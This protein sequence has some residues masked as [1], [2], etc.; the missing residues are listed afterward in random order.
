MRE[1]ET[2][3]NLVRRHLDDHGLLTNKEDQVWTVRYSKLGG[4]GLY[5]KRDIKQGELIF[6]EAPLI[7]GPRCYNKYL[8]MCINCYKSGCPLFPCDRGCGLP[9]CSNQCENS[10]NHVE[11][12]C[13]RL[14]NWQPTCG[15]M[16][17]MELLQTVVPIRSLSLSSYQRDLVYALERHE[18]SL[19]GREI[20]LLKKN[21]SKPLSQEDEEFMLQVC[22]AFDTNAF[23][24]ALRV[25]N[26][27]SISLRGLYPLAA[28]Q[29]HSC[30]PNTRHYFN[31]KGFMFVRAAV[32]IKKDEE[33]TET[34]VDL[35]WGTSLR[36]NYL[37][38]S[39]HFECCCKRCSD[40]TEFGTNISALRCANLKCFS[41]ILPVDPLNFKSPWT[42]R[43]CHVKVSGK[44]IESISSALRMMVN[45]VLNE[46]PRNILKFIEGE[47][48][49]L[50]PPENHI[51]LD[52]KFHVVSFFGRT[53][54][55]EWKNL[56]DRELELKAQYCNELI[57]ILDKLG[58]G[59]CQK[60]GLIFNELYCTKKEQLL[61]KVNKNNNNKDEIKTENNEE[62]AKIASKV[63]E[64]LQN[65]VA[66][67]DDLKQLDASLT[68]TDE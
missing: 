35:I 48:K 38:L 50:V 32:P 15:T 30:L 39:K 12:E 64:I 18:G 45:N 52:M 27:T 46:P 9:V 11:S 60:K 8:P 55:L 31:D 41:Y 58:C 7:I 67:P 43:E 40:P 49:I 56:S 59:D 62:L 14:R 16:W 47:L 34:Y 65:D 19:H 36:R 20:E 68:H 37:V 44:Q 51:L 42:C 4:R 2:T 66:A 5:A 26:K 13:E 10:K 21:I 57:E 25:D 24:T 53:E 22:R 3:E 23:E 17:S 61:R 1:P 28:L 33:L 6:I 29:N 63:V 54:E